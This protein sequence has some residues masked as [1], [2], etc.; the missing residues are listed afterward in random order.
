MS[1]P[2]TGRIGEGWDDPVARI[3]FCGQHRV[4]VGDTESVE[5]LVVSRC[6]SF[7]QYTVTPVC[8]LPGNACVPHCLRMFSMSLSLFHPTSP[9]RNLHCT[10]TL[11]PFPHP[12][13]SIDDSD[14]PPTHKESHLPTPLKLPLQHQTPPPEL[15]HPI[16]RNQLVMHPSRKDHIL[17]EGY[18]HALFPSWAD[19]RAESRVGEKGEISFFN[20]EDTV[21]LG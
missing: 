20:E 8:P 14:A 7:H 13:L 9:L 11:S 17:P 4:H 18:D 21:G 19:G 2:G 12:H 3:H 6:D 5:Q 1:E 16:R 10:T 15:H